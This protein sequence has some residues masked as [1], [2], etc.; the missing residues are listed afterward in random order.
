MPDSP[1]RPT[2][3]ASPDGALEVPTLEAV[4]TLEGGRSLAAP[5]S[6]TPLVI[7]SSPE[8]DLTL[9]DARVSRRHCELVLTERGVM[10]KDL[11]SK[12]G[13][14]IGDVRIVEAQ[15]APGKTATIGAA[16]L[17]V[18]EAGA[19][20]ILPLSTSTRFG[21]VVGSTLPMRVLFARLERA[22]VTQETIL[23]LGESGTG[24]ELIAR[25]IHAASPRRDGPF[26]V[27]DCGALSPN[28]VEA[29]LF[30]YVRGA[31]TGAHAARAGLLEQAE[32]GTLFLDEIGELPLDLQPKL[33]RALESR[34]VRRLG[35]STYKGFDA[36]VVAATH[37]DLAGRVAEGAFREDLYYRLAVVQVVVPPLRERRE[38]I[39]L[40]VQRFLALQT[41]PLSLKDLPP[42][43]LEMLRSHHWPG[44]VREL[45]NTVA[46]L[47]LF[48]DLG[49][50]AILKRPAREGEGPRPLTALPLR[51]AREMAVEQF[52]RAYI[53]EKL[54]EHGGN[55]AQAA[56]A[57]GVSRQLVYR[58]MERY[59]L[60]RGN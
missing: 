26:M 19:P 31:F 30:G 18:R 57:M 13:T 51:E 23:V 50:Q 22:A 35:S 59:G 47:V 52:E 28:L 4:V 36:R 2:L 39:P 6:L 12:N 37:R 33:L 46:R 27:F 15:L 56:D 41:P 55:V 58:L 38:D 60:Q 40:L 54:R 14:L 43:A 21:D 48:P 7:G 5:L 49:E 45:R 9:A 8:C 17:V 32:G 53:S 24:K 29:E 44:N 11:G 10:L 42:G 25:G 1:H 16:S 34:Q 20:S 3:T